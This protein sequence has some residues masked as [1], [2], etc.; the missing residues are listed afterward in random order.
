MSEADQNDD[1]LP[2]VPRNV[3][4]EKLALQFE[5]LAIREGNRGRNEAFAVFALL[6][7]VIAVGSFFS[8]DEIVDGA[9]EEA[10]LDSLAR[11]A[12]G[13][14]VIIEDLRTQAE[15]SIEVFEQDGGYQDLL[16]RL[17]N[18]DQRLQ[19]PLSECRQVTG[20]FN[21]GIDARRDTCSNSAD[22]L[23]FADCGAGEALTSIDIVHNNRESG[24]WRCAFRVT[25]CA[26]FQSGD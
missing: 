23:G 19:N 8:L 22:W 9:I 13:H 17:A 26:V 18:I 25:C 7:F 16:A 6:A 12:E 14:L 20:A 11:D 21:L 24:T 1:P 2:K 4:T 5:H 10:G 15:S 3:D